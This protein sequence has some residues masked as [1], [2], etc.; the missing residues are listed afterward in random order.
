MFL[1]DV[2]WAAGEGL[3]IGVLAGDLNFIGQRCCL[4]ADL[5]C[6]GA[7]V[8]FTDHSFPLNPNQV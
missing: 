6:F 5:I 7:I 1:G 4:V 3:E 8:E 2:D